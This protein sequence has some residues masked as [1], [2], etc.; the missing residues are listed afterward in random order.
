MLCDNF[1]FERWWPKLEADSEHQ[2]E[3][4]EKIH[5]FYDAEKGEATTK[6]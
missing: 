4:D 6:Q 5:S 3:Y 1:L 2:F